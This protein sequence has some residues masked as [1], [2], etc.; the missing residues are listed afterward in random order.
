M[1]RRAWS[2][3]AAC[4]AAL[5]GCGPGAGNDLAFFPRSEALADSAL[6]VTRFDAAQHGALRVRVDQGI[7]GAADVSDIYLR[8]P[9]DAILAG[10]APE[11]LPALEAALGAVAAGPRA[12]WDAHRRGYVS[13]GGA[14]PRSEG[15]Q[16]AATASVIVPIIPESQDPVLAPVVDGLAALLEA[17]S[18]GTL[19]RI[20]APG[21][22]WLQDI[23]VAFDDDT[24]GV[25]PHLDLASFQH[26]VDA[27]HEHARDFMI[28]GKAFTL[29]ARTEAPLRA[30]RD[31]GYRF[32]QL[33]AFVE[34]GN[35]IF[36]EAASGEPRV[37]VGT[38]TVRM[39][40]TFYE[41]PPQEA[42]GLLAEDF[43]LAPEQVVVVPQPDY[44]LDLYLRAGLPGEVLVASREAGARMLEALL[45]EAPASE[46]AALEAVRRRVHRANA[47]P[48]GEA[49]GQRLA[50]VRDALREA[51]FRVIDYPSLYYS[52]FTTGEYVSRGAEYT[53]APDA[54]LYLHV[55]TLNN[56]YVTT[57]D[58]RVLSFVLAS[59]YPAIDRYLADFERHHG[60]DEVYFLGERLAGPRFQGNP[61]L[62]S[63]A[64][65]GCLTNL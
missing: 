59:G 41:I 53:A 50:A 13:G 25:P 44:H 29:G 15:I 48:V 19:V 11:V 20:Q 7:R 51:G 39:T 30:L 36:T 17:R 31:R 21:G 10:T 42:V 60:V 12:L 33:R 28:G 9:G 43:G 58:G 16:T 2:A 62:L 24:L 52:Y 40:A 54:A 38:N 5:S 3:A 45:L 64:G 26:T 57:Q 6:G 37:L 14:R 18:S 23:L 47:S 65:V 22:A 63:A 34:G 8:A 35:V 55:N 56:R 49:L 46:R 61:V 27:V 4:L 1:S 32:R